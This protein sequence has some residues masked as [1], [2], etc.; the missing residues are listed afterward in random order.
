[1][2]KREEWFISVCICCE[3]Y[4]LQTPENDSAGLVAGKGLFRVL[5]PPKK[6]TCTEG[7]A[8]LSVKVYG[9][10]LDAACQGGC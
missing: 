10:N 4:S 7:N 6:Y 3:I 9:P 5:I 8:P 1:M 2:R